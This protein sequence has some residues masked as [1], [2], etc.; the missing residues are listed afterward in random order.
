MVG[1]RGQQSGFRMCRAPT[2]R[3][4][5]CSRVIPRDNRGITHRLIG[6]RSQPLATANS[7]EEPDDD[8]NNESVSADAPIELWWDIS[9]LVEDLP[10]DEQFSIPM[11]D[12]FL[13]NFRSFT[14][15]DNRAVGLIF[16]NHWSSEAIAY[17]LNDD[18]LRDRVRGVDLTRSIGFDAASWEALATVILSWPIPL[19][20]LELCSV[21]SDSLGEAFL[22]PLIQANHLRCLRARDVDTVWDHVA[23]ALATCHSVTRVAI[24]NVAVEK[25]RPVFQALATNS[26][27]DS[28]ELENL[29]L[30]TADLEILVPILSE[31]ESI[32]NLVVEGV[33]VPNMDDHGFAAEILQQNKALKS[34]CLRKLDL[35][36]PES[37]RIGA[38][39]LDHPSLTRLELDVTLAEDAS[40][41]I[42]ESLEK[43]PRLTS[44]S[45][46]GT[47]VTEE[48]ARRLERVLATT[49]TLQSLYLTGD[50]REFSPVVLDR[51]LNGLVFNTTLNTIPMKMTSVSLIRRL[52]RVVDCNTFL[53]N[54]QLTDENTLR[55][56][57]GEDRE[58]TQAW[59]E[60][61]MNMALGRPE[62]SL[63][64]PYCAE[65]LKSHFDT[66]APLVPVGC[67][68]ELMRRAPH[69]V[70]L[71]D[72]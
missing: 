6:S 58:F 41:G 14:N 12:F 11:V 43:N 23:D 72:K 65:R 56:I 48:G 50:P 31:K 36:G 63:L 64:V 21:A 51:V 32:C 15:D 42:L 59:F 71:K 26:S 62:Y 10:E 66:M 1:T 13:Q 9:A 20:V 55:A 5:M 54:F 19:S 68:F 28:L 4:N 17:M 25:V 35:S 46:R 2:L 27:I 37:T 34:L 53:K 40:D 44:F 33:E 60:L 70:R 38:A 8:S 16:D 7:M 39:C 52:R 29:T 67:W 22:A 18:F 49:E 30:N 61:S 3:P 69:R 24:D 45:I 57:R 47:E